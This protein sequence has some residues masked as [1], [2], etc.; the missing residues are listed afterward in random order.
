MKYYDIVLCDVPPTLHKRL[1]F[2]FMYNASKLVSRAAH[3]NAVIVSN[4][5]SILEKGVLGG[6]KGVVPEGF[7]FSRKLLSLMEERSAILYIPFSLMLAN[8]GFKLS[9]NLRH[10]SQLFYYARKK[11]IHVGFASFAQS[12]EQLLSSIQII[13][14]AVLIGSSEQYA[15]YSMSEINSLMFKMIK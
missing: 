3:A 5:P 6:A 1:G 8:G 14:L 12:Q 7:R 15:R 2:A 10:A 9:S 11:N 4:D 13:K